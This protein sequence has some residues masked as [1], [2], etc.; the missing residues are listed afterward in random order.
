[1]VQHDVHQFP[2]DMVGGK[3]DFLGYQRIVGI[4]V[5]LVARYPRRLSRPG[6]QR[7]GQ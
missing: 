2:Q 6:Q 1:M 4:H 3:M 7:A 5:E